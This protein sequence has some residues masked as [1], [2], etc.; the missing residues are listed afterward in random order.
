MTEENITTLSLLFWI[1]F[2]I[3][4]ICMCYEFPKRKFC[5]SDPFWMIILKIWGGFFLSIIFV[6]CM[7]ILISWVFL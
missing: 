4:Y 1:P 3:T 2:F 6:V 7:C 5:D